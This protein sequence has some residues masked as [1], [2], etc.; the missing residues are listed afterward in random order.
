MLLTSSDLTLVLHLVVT[1]M[2]VLLA[3]WVLPGIRVKSFAHALLFACL[4]AVLNTLLWSKLGAVRGVPQLLSGGVGTLALNGALFYVAGKLAPG[5]EVSGC[6]TAAI[7]A[8][9]VS[10]LNGAIFSVAREFLR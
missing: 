3:G 7:G 1:A 5:I 8:F 2:S 6:V 4:T 10:F 9:A